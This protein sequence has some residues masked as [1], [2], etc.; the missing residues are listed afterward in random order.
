MA[1]GDMFTNLERIEFSAGHILCDA[2]H[3]I[4]EGRLR[5]QRA[6]RV[7]E[8][9]A[10]LTIAVADGQ[11]QRLCLYCDAREARLWSDRSIL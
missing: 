9:A 6:A 2:H 1:H 8:Y 4:A 3:A 11:L 7:S 5:V 10:A